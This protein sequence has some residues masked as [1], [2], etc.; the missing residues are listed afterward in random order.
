MKLEGQFPHSHSCEGH[1]RYCLLC[2]EGAGHR[3]FLA[4]V[5]CTHCAPTVVIRLLSFAGNHEK[6]VFISP[7]WCCTPQV[8]SG[9]AEA[10]QLLLHP[11]LSIC[12]SAETEAESWE[13]TDVLWDRTVKLEWEGVE[14]V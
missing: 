4:L 6:N 2:Q 10:S 9:N 13:L 11:W 1:S 5:H 14:L 7:S 3:I 12:P 8:L